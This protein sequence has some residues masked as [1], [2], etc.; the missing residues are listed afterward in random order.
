MSKLVEAQNTRPQG[1]F[2]SHTKLNPRQ[3]IGITLR[4]QRDLEKVPK[5]Q[6]DH[7][8]PTKLTRQ[9]P[10]TEKG[11]KNMINIVEYKRQPPPFH[12]RL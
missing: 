4:Y 2:P 7:E 10:T 12:Q 3:L 8:V 6:K 5:E 1:G 9:S 11:S